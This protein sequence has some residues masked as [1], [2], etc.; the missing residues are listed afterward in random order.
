M[1]DEAARIWIGIGSLPIASEGFP[2]DADIASLFTEEE[3]ERQYPDYQYSLG[4][5]EFCDRLQVRG[6]TARHAREALGAVLQELNSEMDAE[7]FFTDSSGHFL[8]DPYWHADEVL[9]SLQT[10]FNSP[11]GIDHPYYFP[12]DQ[13]LDIPRLGLLASLR[14]I[15]D[16]VADRSQRVH[17]RFDNNWA[18]TYN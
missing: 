3:L 13:R 7:S 12:P 17:Y 16:V 1:D 14:L 8:V 9:D 15:L 5:D 6:L 11:R 2:Y 18:A 4:L 10:Y